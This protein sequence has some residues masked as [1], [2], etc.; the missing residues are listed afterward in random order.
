MAIQVLPKTKS[1]EELIR[2]VDSVIEIIGKSGLNY[3]VGPFETTV[4]GD[5]LEEILDL[6]KKCQEKCITEGADTVTSYIKLHHS[7]QSILSIDDKVAK[8]QK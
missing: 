8:Y 6:L 7:K 5:N 4:E 2:I 1:D 3:F